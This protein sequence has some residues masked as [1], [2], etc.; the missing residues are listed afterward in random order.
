LPR[1][2]ALGSDIL[3]EDPEVLLISAPA[4]PGDIVTLFSL[5]AFFTPDACFVP[6]TFFRATSDPVV[7]APALAW[8]E[9][10]RGFQ[11]RCAQLRDTQ[12]APQQRARLV[13]TR[14]A[15]QQSAGGLVDAMARW[16]TRFD[17]RTRRCH[18]Y[19][20]AASHST[21]H[22]VVDGD[23]RA[24]SLAVAPSCGSERSY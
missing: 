14:T 16:V 4:G 13:S 15:S 7:P 3:A 20:S 11:S 6:A 17:T 21:S 23:C 2:N 10:R 1:L 8:P 19:M 24:T 18:D 12:T 5:R 9:R 22:C